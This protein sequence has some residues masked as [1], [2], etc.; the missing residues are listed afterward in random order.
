[1][2][3]RTRSLLI[4]L[5]LLALGLLVVAA[6]GL[7]AYLL[8]DLPGPEQ[9][10]TRIQRPSTQILDR[11]GRLLYEVIDPNGSKQTP[12]PLDQMP[13]ACRQAVIATEDKLFY[14]HPGVDL[15]AIGR[16]V[17]QN[18][19]AGTTVSGA[20]TITQQLARNLLLD[21]DERYEQTL[22][23]KLRE[24]WLA[25]RLE[26][27]YSKDQL[28]ELY[29]NQAYFG[30]FAV[31][32]EAAAQAYFGVSARELDVAQC[33]LLAGLLQ[34][35]S[36]YNPLIDPAAARNRQT[37]VLRLMTEQ[38]YLDAQQADLARHEP[39]QY[40]ATPFPIQAPH[41]V[42]FVNNWLER[43]FGSDAV[44]R[45][46]LRVTTTLDLDWQNRAQAIAQR[47]LQDLRADRKASPNRRV[48]NAALVAL[49]PQTGQ[50]VA[51]LGSPDYFD[52]RIQGNVNAA[53]SLRQPG[54]AIKPLTYAAAFDPKRAQAAGKPP[55]TPATLVSD[56]RTAFP[57]R[58]GDPYVPLNYDL[59]FHGP[60]LLRDALGSSF[61]VPAVKVL[62]H[63][64]V[65]ALV[66]LAQQL[67]ISSFV[68]QDDF[69]LALTL[70]GGEVRLLELTAA[71]GAFANGGQRVVPTAVLQVAD[72]EGNV[73]YHAAEAAANAVQHQVLS[74]QVAYLITSILSD[75][76]ARLPTF[77]GHSLL[78]L[79]GDRPAAVKT[80]TT[81]D[82]K[83]N[84]T[85]GYTPDLVVGVWV[86]NADN[87]PMQGISGVTGAGPIWHDFMENVLRDQPMQT[88][89]RP[90]GL[91]DVEICADSGQLATTLCPRTRWEVFLDGTQ[92]TQ[93]DT[94]HQLVTLD[95][96]T[97]QRATSTTPAANRVYKNYWVLPP[98]L[99]EWA[100]AHG[101]EQPPPLGAA[102][103]TAAVRDSSPSTLGTLDTAPLVLTSPDAARVY[104]IS[105][106]QPLDTQ[107][108]KVVARGNVPLRQVTIL[109]NDQ[110]LDSR[111]DSQLSTWWR[112]QP[113]QHTF[114]ATGVTLDGKVVKSEPIVITVIA[115]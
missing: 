25:W 109:V 72:T 41:F 46:G 113:G 93:A 99:L 60:V 6:V 106:A 100:R 115:G 21:A 104:R 92:P 30:N 52:D 114:Q 31:G 85:I 48:D 102:G 3:I 1:M 49:H 89:T 54:S 95:S 63:V 40:A 15:L 68:A 53:L 96:R 45:G 42:M 91:V 38:G 82:W 27:V 108:V 97:G 110:P 56:V 84:W 55:L 101:I 76:N 83:D 9:S 33:A 94:M 80:G 22:R 39:L 47:R 5:C 11:H 112:L 20:S 77:G 23:R 66:D 74:P 67:G 103:V 26:H 50:I 8:A 78:R 18:T 58:E 14:E 32:I 79:T 4:R 17:W 43:Q 107:E 81:T 59:Q 35:P 34:S 12:L 13:T 10:R 87:T 2:V 86:G 71:Y 105:P 73:L 24:A 51:M 36:T 28:L 75:N 98:D 16:A 65:P 90:P 69:G 29:L 57:T 37:V 62:Q 44:L 7:Y 64:G 61:N 70:G 88:F 19:Q 111:D